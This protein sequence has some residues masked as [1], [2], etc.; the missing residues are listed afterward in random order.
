MSNNLKIPSPVS[1]LALFMGLAGGALIFYGI[2]GGAI[3]QSAGIMSE[4]RTGTAWDNPRAINILKWLQALSSIMVFGIPGYF[5]ARLVFRDRPLY[6]LGLR[7][8]VKIN[9]YLLAI[10]LLLISLPLEGWLGELNKRLPLRAWMIQAEKSNDRQILAFLKVNTPFD[11][12]INLLVMA[13]L[14]AFFEELCFRGALQR[15]LIN[16][17]RSPW[18]GIIV[19]GFLFSAIH[20]QFEGFLPRM[21][22]GI[23]LGAAYWYSGSLWASILAHFFFNGIQITAAMFYPDVVS[24]N[25]SIPVYTVL[26]SMV[27]VVGLLYRMRKQSGVSY[28]GVFH[29]DRP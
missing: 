13:A 8:A 11:I 1:Q 14:P 17:F 22:L 18:A 26:L 4:I 2:I 3:Q 6:Q 10:L 23:L 21:F 27:I 16:L 15:I 25:P 5:Y 29:T 20:V 24:R 9:F 7:P 19:T 28:A 12:F